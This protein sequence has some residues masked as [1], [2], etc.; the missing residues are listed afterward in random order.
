MADEKIK[1]TPGMHYD[2]L[3]E[4]E[5]QDCYL[6]Y[7][8][9]VIVARALPD[10]RDGLKPVHR[11]VLFAMHKLGLTA[12]KATMKSARIVGE[13]IGKYHPHGDAAAYDTLVRMAQDF[14]LRYPLVR[15]QGNF[16][17][18]DG[19]SAAAMRYTEAKMTRVGELM[20]DD[21]DKETVDM[22]KNYDETLDEP[23]VLPAALPNLLVNGSSGIAVG[24]ATNIPPHNLREV[25]RAIH[26]YCENNDITGEELLN[27]V[28]GPD[29]PTGGI[30]CGRAGIR[31][32][33]LTGRGRV[34]VRARVEIE[35]DAKG[36]ERLIISE[37]PYMVNKAL[38]VKNM[39][40]LVRDKRIDGISDI[41][42]ESDREG[43]RVVVDIKR[44]FQGDIVLN[45]LYKYTQLED[46]FSIYNLAL[47]NRTQPT[48]LPLK[49][50]IRYYV[51]HRLEV[52]LRRT[53]FDLKKAQARMHILEALRVACSNVDEVVAIIK[54]SKS[55]ED[56]KLNLKDRYAFDD[57][58][59]QA[60]VDMQL[61]RITGLEIEK[62]ENEY[63]QLVITVQDLEDIIA[64]KERRVQI[65]LET[66]DAITEKFGDER[67]TSIENAVQDYDSEDLIPEEEQVITLSR[68]G[69]VKRL[70]IGTFKAQNRGGKG[71]IGA[72]LK[73]ED[74]IQSIF[75]ASTHSYLLVFTNKGRVYWTK[76]YNLPEGSRNG[77]GRPIVN[78]VNLTT[79]EKVSAIVPV[80]KF[81][82]YNCLVFAT[83]NGVINK[84]DLKVFSN[85]RRSGVNAISLDEGDELVKVLLVGVTAEEMEA[86]ARGE[87]IDDDANVAEVEE[88]DVESADEPVDSSNMAKDLLMLATK[89]GQAITFPIS[90]LRTMG[91][92]THGVRGIR[93]MDADEVI[94]LLWLKSERKVLTISENGY[95]KRS[96]PAAYRI[97]RRGGKGV[98]N[99]N[100]TEKTGC[101]V[102]V[103]SVADD[104]DL[105]ITSREGQVI[106]I[107]V[108]S[109]RLTGRV[110][111]GVKAITLAENDKVQD[112]TALPS[113]DD[114]EQESV[115]AQA[116]AESSE[117]ESP[118]EIAE[119]VPTPENP[120]DGESEN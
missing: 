103:D 119:D 7:S 13:V 80:R 40:D 90:S 107:P 106:R 60:I 69:Y 59:A 101:A 110:S 21:L 22:G 114:I 86:S 20:L 46:T 18:V 42:D 97:T 115:E 88:S 26:A 108:E 4:R 30:I 87:D 19:D 85:P 36:R 45:N 74:N 10:V 72:G 76:V 34:R 53:Q 14:S 37:I 105:I 71:I 56:A 52:I 43:M 109:I 25:T 75:T 91:R 112:A 64:R 100:I 98:R 117:G 16:G 27:Y 23:L 11:R 35:K 77:K 96:E 17:S 92:G 113:D 29:F 24:M 111:Q 104:Y 55:T 31:D 41:R 84:M 99:L 81:G 5:M 48:L 78:F 65:L 3:I 116:G 47:V 120:A 79:G 49:D 95:G 44:D 102:F 61:K 50:M 39:A 28:S 12:D 33:Y 70:P 73:D 62:L 82:G 54:N 8:M 38:L 1:L 118:V 57:I 66:L 15:G 93:L 63:Q 94:A 83:K 2:S 68:E 6:R 32:A 58:Q 89:N 9:S 67:R 51:D